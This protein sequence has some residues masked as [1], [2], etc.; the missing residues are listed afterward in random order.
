MYTYTY[1]HIHVHTHIHK[2]KHSNIMPEMNNICI[3]FMIRVE[4]NY[5]MKYY[6]FVHYIFKYSYIL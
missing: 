5:V 6:K 1:T 2:Y 3:L 4:F